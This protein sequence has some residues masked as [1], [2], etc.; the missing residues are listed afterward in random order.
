MTT[1][2][3]GKDAEESSNDQSQ[4]GKDTSTEEAGSEEAGS[5]ASQSGEADT[6]TLEKV[7]ELALGLQKGYTQTRQDLATIGDNIAK[8]TDAMNTKTGAQE[9]DEEYVTVGNMKQIISEALSANASSANKQKDDNDAQIDA[10]LAELQASGQIKTDETDDLIA[11]AVKI[12][13]PDLRKAVLSYNEVKV[14]GSNAAKKAVE[15]A[16]KAAAKKKEGGGVGG[17]SQSTG[18]EQGGIDYAK[19]KQMQADGDFS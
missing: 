13:Q 4:E 14:A 10:Q 5:D 17:S 15:D 16:A 12:K 2:D 1:D 3:Q 11:H 19:L 6:L 7:N 8:I 9:G 18:S